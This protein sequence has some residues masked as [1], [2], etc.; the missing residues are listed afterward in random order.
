MLF[1]C[2]ESRGG[3][4]GSSL[5]LKRGLSLIPKDALRM[6]PKVRRVLD[7]VFKKGLRTAILL[8]NPEETL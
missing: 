1:E 3:N 5:V 4:V 8:G 7:K 2:K 6:D